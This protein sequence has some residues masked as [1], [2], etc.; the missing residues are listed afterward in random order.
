MSA[1]WQE[2]QAF[3][4]LKGHNWSDDI[5]GCH[6]AQLRGTVPITWSASCLY[7]PTTRPPGGDVA[8]LCDIWHAWLYFVVLQGTSRWL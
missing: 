1:L 7:P 6:D 8:D 2:L 4:Y 5:S 3:C